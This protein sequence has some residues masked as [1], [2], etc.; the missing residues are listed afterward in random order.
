M[1]RNS[2]P[3]A[4]R[5]QVYLARCGLGSRRSCDVLAASG[6]VAINGAR[7]TRAGEKVMPGD[8]V[9]LDGRKVA[10]AA[11]QVYIALHKPPGFLCANADPEHRPLA[12]DL[13]ASAIKERLF[14]VGRL[15]FLSSGLILYTNDGDF[16]KVVSHPSARIQKEYLV[17]TAREIEEAFLHQYSRGMRVG[18]VTYR[19]ESYTQRGPK[20]A[21]ITLTEGKNRELRNVFSSRNIRLKRV[22]RLR[23]G[24]I[25]LHGIAPGH[26]RRLTDRE[27]RWFLDHAA[28][29]RTDHRAPSR[30]GGVPRDRPDRAPPG[31]RPARS[32]PANRTGRVPPAGRPGP[33]GRRP[34]P[35]DRRP[36]SGGDAPPDRRRR[37]AH[38]QPGRGR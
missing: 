17:E 19:C 24:P 2:E 14:H 28:K 8:V 13:F 32:A 26:F 6:R 33:E 5:L 31:H 12:R 1:N 9:T 25:T 35:G 3:G 37:D 22:H 36:R 30:P 21:V 27:V 38:D 23:I 4:I 10:A 7:V 16:A 20:S 34:G 15:D 11:R 29:E 18:E